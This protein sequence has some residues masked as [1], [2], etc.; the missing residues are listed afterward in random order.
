[1]H[2][3][4]W[5]HAGSVDCMNTVLRDNFVELH[6]QPLLER[7]LQEFQALYPHLDF[8]ELPALVRPVPTDD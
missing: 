6:S 7:L 1:M 2:D 8:P 3:S 4:F 5:T